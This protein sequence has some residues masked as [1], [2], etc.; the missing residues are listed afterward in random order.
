MSGSTSFAGGRATEAG[1]SFQAAVGAWFAA[2]VVSD[3]S[4]G[5][6]I[7]LSENAMSVR[8]QFETGSYLDDIEV[9]QSDGGKILVQCKTNLNL[10]SRPN[11][12]LAR[13]VEQLV[14]FFVAYQ[15]DRLDGIDL[16]LC[17]AVLAVE[18]TAPSSLDHLEEACRFFDYGA[19]IKDV[20]SNL[21]K[22]RQRALNIFFEHVRT[23]WSRQARERLNDSDLSQLARLFRIVR[24]DVSKDGRDAA[25]ASQ[26]LSQHLLGNESSD[27]L[28]YA[29]LGSVVRTMTRSGAPADRAGLI[30]GLRDFGVKDTQNPH[31][32]KDIAQL[33]ALAEAECSRLDRH[34]SLPIGDGI[35]IERS[36]T[37]ALRS[38]I[39]N[40]S[41]LVVGEPGAGKTGVLVELANELLE[42]NTPFVFLSVDQFS[43]STTRDGL[44]T[45]L[46]LENK[47]QDVLAAWP[48]SRSGVL[49][50]DALDAS[51]GA[52]S[53]V[54][55]A[56]LIEDVLLR[57]GE[58]WSVIASI[59]TFDLQH[60]RRFR[61]AFAGVPPAKQFAKSDFSDVS[62]FWIPRLTEQELN[63]VAAMHSELGGLVT[64]APCKLQELLTNVFNLSIAAG[65]VQQ[66]ASSESIATISTQ[67]DLIER[68]EDERLD[69]H[70]LKRV[71]L[72]TVS[73]MV[74]LRR[75]S[76]RKL[77]VANDAIDDVLQTGILIES[78]DKVSFAHHILFDHAAGRW[79]LDADQ[80]AQLLKQMSADQSIGLLLGPALRFTVERIWRQDK[81]SR[82]LSWRFIADLAMTSEPDPIAL[83]VALRAVVEFVAN[84]T[85]VTGL[86]ELIHG[87][88]N[89]KEVSLTLR[90]IARFAA[91]E[92]GE[93]APTPPIAIAW[94]K[95][96][97]TALSTNNPDFI[98]G[99][100]YLLWSLY[101]K[102]NFQDSE[103]VEE[104]GLASRTYLEICWSMPT[105][106]PIAVR[107]G[108]QMV[109]K[110]FA[111]DADRSRALLGRIF[112]EPHFTEHAH[113]E[114][115]W[116][117]EG[118]PAIWR[119][120]PDFAAEI[121]EVAFGR[122]GPR[123]GKTWIGGQPSQILPLSSNR[124]QDYEH[125][126]W[127]L[128]QTFPDFLSA[129]PA[130]AA[131]AVNA[132]TIGAAVES[133]IRDKIETRKIDVADTSVSIVI[134]GQA[135]LNWRESSNRYSDDDEVISA[136]TR[137]LR[138]CDDAQFRALLNVAIG[139]ETAT[140]IWARMFGVAAE[141]P[142]IPDRELWRFATNLKFLDVLD[143]RRDAIIYLAA[144]YSNRSVSEREH[145][146]RN[147]LEKCGDTESQWARSIASRFISEV[148]RELLVLPEFKALGEEFKAAGD[149]QGNRPVMTF[150]GIIE[151]DEEITDI[152]L[153]DRGVELDI[154]GLDRR[155]RDA[156]RSIEVLIEPRNEEM[157]QEQV[158]VLWS[159]IANAI[160]TVSPPKEP[161]PH[162]AMLH[163]LWGTI[164]N[165]VLAI[166]Y[167]S[168]YDPGEARHPDLVE[169][170]ALIDLM[171]VSP[172]PET[173]D[174]DDTSMLA[175]GNLDV[176]VY[177]VQS[178]IQMALR[179]GNQRPDFVARLRKFLND[180]VPTV[181]LQICSSLYSLWEMP[182]LERW[183][184]MEE[185]SNRETNV[186]V[187][188]HFIGGPLRRV[189]ESE[190]ERCE[191]LAKT[192]I[193]RVAVDAKV[194]KSGSKDCSE[195]L[196][197]LAA[198]LW[199]GR[200]RSEAG[201]WIDGWTKNLEDNIKYIFPLIGLLRRGY[202]E[203]YIFN[204]EESRQ[205]QSRSKKIIHKVV[206]L[207]CTQLNKS[208]CKL[209]SISLS[210]T[211]R[212]QVEETYRE[213]AKLLDHACNQL[214]FGSGAFRN[215]NNKEPPGLSSDEAKR[216]F[217]EE[218]SDTVNLLANHGTAHTLHT[219]IELYSFLAE[220]APALVFD[221]VAGLLL[222]QATKEGY[223]FEALGSDAIV[224]L[225]RRYLADYREIFDD[226]DRRARLLSVL[227]LFSDAGWPEA[228]K[229]LYELP[230]L[231]R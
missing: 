71:T 54:T 161:P 177:A 96:A 114:L 62:H 155:V 10:S 103:F 78:G 140:A 174:A 6:R 31:V 225:I 19:D 220:A 61:S 231:L 76:I 184:I 49:M 147:L 99:A 79:F 212:N 4:V 53:E 21:S 208:R 154:D 20:A 51:R 228:L 129:N 95:L 186:G 130:S 104:F 60:G 116:L 38:A 124:K 127:R 175:W 193:D 150:S 122:S 23:A 164:S 120:Q 197:G 39:N 2:H 93:I 115:P 139:S 107:F 226:D 34:R 201:S 144:A 17:A 126:R 119:S 128:R 195:A 209:T 28:I 200:G 16:D 223:H 162:E 222:G 167:A 157:S 211:S 169:V 137:F 65:L 81:I 7:G 45:E 102:A 203:N 189:S 152:L 64:S 149:L 113:E 112:D 55:F 215:S 146:E 75:L 87:E 173:R 36:C 156:V 207:T 158:S 15:E 57:S 85:D 210:E 30:R 178:L 42:S 202:F 138:E 33:T 27:Q 43:E 198:R 52:S 204:T 37:P 170:I 8:I 151:S 69:S 94:V 187:L 46:G 132:V 44:T 3:I 221:H 89:S 77:E 12:S 82:S 160:E 229:L 217:L 48:G 13:T 67:S 117:A 153:K 88:Q 101:E 136:Y 40:G 105:H 97:R 22:A 148:N 176:R 24:F 29:A 41:L 110:S 171:A 214:Y 66:G 83:S 74:R 199:V 63:T 227:E 181:R 80:P 172:Y 163:S 84:P 182:C 219:L 141:R 143:L 50:I 125:A 26:I 25:F 72:E 86:C 109:C 185:I 35:P 159:A 1:L 192:I 142:G 70:R 108:I 121:F 168:A 133:G 135:L 131:R 14:C 213:Y 100:R 56:N 230:D 206:Y 11:S 73:A 47:L 180:P 188:S 218:Y 111:T 145:F 91:L 59:R 183:E 123:D 216:Q 179:F 166:S 98:D 196:A 90:K 106:N 5:P 190:P 58:R 224:G 118:L 134:D 18:S 9:R 92:L 165:A 194:V 32:Q 191:Q 68:Y 205:I